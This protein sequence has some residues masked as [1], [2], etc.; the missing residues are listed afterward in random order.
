M[1]NDTTYQTKFAILK[2]W[3][4]NIID[5][6]RKDLKKDHLSKDPLFLKQ[7]LGG[8]PVHKLTNEELVDGYSA[9]LENSDNAEAVGEFISNRWL[10]KH[11]DLYYLF[12][13]HMIQINPDVTK[14]VKLEE[15]QAQPII[16]EAVA[17][18]G[19]VDTYLFCRINSVALT[20]NTFKK[21]EKQAEAEDA[22]E[23]EEGKLESIEDV[24]RVYQQMIARLTDKYE[25][26]LSSL[27]RKYVQD[28]DT[29]KKHIGNLQ[30]KLTA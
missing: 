8:K 4:P 22:E 28:T 29:L 30:R 14:I 7:H 19:A 18:F 15:S 21:L 26:K 27:E 24:E 1:E 6:V 2:K 10:L 13:Q 5:T 9:V 23:I 11:A 25:K 16:E 3:L 17:E 20:E 12:E